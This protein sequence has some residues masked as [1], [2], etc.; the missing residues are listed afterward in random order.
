MGLYEYWRDISPGSPFDTVTRYRVESDDDS[1]VSDSFNVPSGNLGPVHP[2]VGTV[3]LDN[4]DGLTR[5]I[6]K[7]IGSSAGLNIVTTLNDPACCGSISFGIFEVNKTNNTDPLGSNGTITIEGAGATDIN[8]Y[9]ASIDGGATWV[10]PTSDII[11]FDTLAAGTYSIIIRLVGSPCTTSTSVSITDQFTYPPLIVEESSQPDLYSPVFRPIVLGFTLA[12]N[13][14]D[15]GSDVNGTFMEAPTT[16]AAEYLATF[17]IVRIINNVDYAGKYQVLSRSTPG[18]PPDVGTRFYIN[19]TYTTDQTVYFVP[20]ERQVF[21]LYAETDFN[22]YTKIADIAVYPDDASP[23]GEYKLRLEGFL[24]SAFTLLA[25]VNNGP[26]LSLLRNYYVQ[27][28]NFETESAPTIYKAVYSTSKSL[29]PFLEDLTP[30][31][32]APINFINE[33]TA[34]GLPVLFSYIN[35]ETGRVENITSSQETDIVSTSPTVYIAGLPLNTYELT[36]INPAG[37]ISV[38]NITPALPSWITLTQPAADTIHLLIDL[39][40]GYNGDYDP[41]DYDEEDYLTGG[42]NSIVGCYSFLFEDGTTD[43]FTLSICVFPIEKSNDECIDD[44]FNIAWMNSDGGWSS[45]IFAGRKA[46][47]V[48]IGDVSTFKQGDIKKRSS[49]TEVYDSRQCF[50]VNKAKR[51]LDFIG[52]LKKSIQAFLY[53]EDT[54][55]WSI[56]ILIDD[57]SFDLYELPFKQIEV[58]GSLKFTYGEETKVQTQ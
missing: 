45:Y 51:D 38:L 29:T 56:P 55:Q 16:D 53:D 20:F 27:P 57:A 9:E 34:K 10:S 12:N 46:Y 39:S 43:L 26:D 41:D 35:T 4:C 23:V 30:L 36:W 21:E 42:A 32:P 58:N 7:G 8:D 54:Q 22:T 19:A 1:Y 17:P 11:T 13:Q 6:Y 48:D 18:D 40:Q 2:P 15:I 31:G 47:G 3:I 25:P 49:V 37:P 24:Q 28:L 52:S 44:A 50:I 5:K 14:V 33:Q